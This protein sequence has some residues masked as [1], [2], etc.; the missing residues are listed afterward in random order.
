MT[1]GSPGTPASGEP[2]VIV[3]DG[4]PIGQGRISY[5]RSGAGYYSNYKTLKPWRAA[6]RAAAMRLYGLHEWQGPPKKNRDK[7]CLQC[8]VV[9]YMHALYPLEPI[10]FR[11][12]CVFAPVASAPGRLEP[13]VRSSGDWDHLGRAIGDALSG[14][15]WADDS[16]IVDGRVRKYYTT[17]HRAPL[18]DP[19]SVIW[20]WPEDP[21]NRP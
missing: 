2:V 6:V 5:N 14:V 15:I 8:G 13:T 21:C 16:Q 17:H 9:R 4:D 3:V 11:A 18:G 20:V 12:E 7:P 19:G 10:V 1:T